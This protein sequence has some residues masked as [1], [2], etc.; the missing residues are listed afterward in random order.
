MR[1]A[2]SPS[3]PVAFQHLP[4]P[5]SPAPIRCRTPAFLLLSF[6]FPFPSLPVI[7][8]Q[9]HPRAA[10]PGLRSTPAQQQRTA[11]G[12]SGRGSTQPLPPRADAGGGGAAAA[13]V[14][15]RSADADADAA[16][17][18]A[19]AAIPSATFP[20]PPRLALARLPSSCVGALPDAAQLTN[21]TGGHLLQLPLHDA[22]PHVGQVVAED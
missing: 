16:A 3:S 4:C 10:T 6:C 22:L 20:L 17:A 1:P 15:A 9:W 5:S 11:V 19:A 2:F 21:L 18:A 13:V 12:G 14:V 7:A 8:A